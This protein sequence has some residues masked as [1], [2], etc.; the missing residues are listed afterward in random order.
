MII[1]YRRHTNW[2]LVLC[3]LGKKLLKLSP[4]MSRITEEYQT[5]AF[6]PWPLLHACAIVKIQQLSILYRNICGPIFLAVLNVDMLHSSQVSKESPPKKIQV[7]PYP[8]ILCL[9]SNW[10]RHY[11]PMQHLQW[12][13]SCYM[14]KCASKIQKKTNI[15][16]R[17]AQI[18]L[19]YEFYW[20]DTP[21]HLVWC[22]LILFRAF[23]A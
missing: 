15:L 11:D 9:P 4:S 12:V 18:A 19:V 17:I 22:N 23:V 21:F 8:S 16:Y 20:V 1:L 13:V 6:L 10:R 3:N 5:V 2:W 7:I 14:H